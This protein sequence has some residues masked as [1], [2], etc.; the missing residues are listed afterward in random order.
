MANYYGAQRFGRGGTN[1]E[2]G[3]VLLNQSRRSRHWKA[4]LMLSAYQSELFNRWLAARI[5]SGHFET[6][7]IGDVAKKTDTGGL[8]VVENLGEEQE[9]LRA[10]AITYTGPIFGM[11]MMA[12]TA[13]AGAIEAALLAEAGLNSE[14]FR[15]QRLQ[16]SR[17]VARLW[18]A[19]FTLTAQDEGL[20]FAFSLPKGAYA[21]VLLR[22]FIDE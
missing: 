6:L 5:Q 19:D 1:A 10:G 13:A 21:T 11:K 9:R 17:R 20:S 4:Q 22:E 7:L 8:F 18:P 16:G 15:A 14:S 2:R 3:R 12:A